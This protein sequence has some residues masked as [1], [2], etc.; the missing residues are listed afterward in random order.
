MKMSV[1]K[2]SVHLSKGGPAVLVPGGYSAAVVEIT[3]ETDAEFALIR[4]LREQGL[5]KV[6]EKGVIKMLV[7]KISSISNSTQW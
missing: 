6:A 2:S 4:K 1:I 3:A 5:A 7:V